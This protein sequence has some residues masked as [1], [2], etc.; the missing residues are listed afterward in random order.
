[1]SIKK[2]SGFIRA[3]AETILGKIILGGTLFYYT[4]KYTCLYFRP[5]LINDLAD[6][7]FL[8]YLM[9]VVFGFIIW[10][11]SLIIFILCIIS[12]DQFKQTYKKLYGSNSE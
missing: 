5:D 12:Y 10:F 2:L 11:V 3:V 8:Y 4:G 1:M 6:M 7:P 9:P